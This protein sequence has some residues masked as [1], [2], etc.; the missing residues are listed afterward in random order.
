MDTWRDQCNRM[1]R[2]HAREIKRYQERA[3]QG[4]ARVQ[5]LVREKAALQNQ[6]MNTERELSMCKSL[7]SSSQTLI[8]SGCLSETASQT[9][10][11][12][13]LAVCLIWCPWIS[14]SESTFDCSSK[15]QRNLSNALMIRATTSPHYSESY[16]TSKR[17][18][19]KAR[20]TLAS[21]LLAL[22]NDTDMFG[23]SSTILKLNV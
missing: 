17:Y 19:R 4:D 16:S 5:E 11:S 6:A 12:L 2:D 13:R 1:E 8:S 9:E 20:K 10:A 14:I 21:H 15:K 22:Q 7:L 3:N 23:Y 18:T